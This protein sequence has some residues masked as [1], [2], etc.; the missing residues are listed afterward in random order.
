MGGMA[1]GWQLTP[2]TWLAREAT[3]NGGVNP[4]LRGGDRH[5]QI[6]RTIGRGNGPKRGDFRGL[7]AAIG[8]A[9]GRIGGLESRE[10]GV[11]CVREGKLVGGEWFSGQNQTLCPRQA[12]P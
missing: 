10:K 8:V 12:R 7:L 3:V 4:P 9:K 6:V 2:D 5:G 1:D 11:F